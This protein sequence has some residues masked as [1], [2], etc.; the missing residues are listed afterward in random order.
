MD[1]SEEFAAK[2]ERYMKML[3]EVIVIKKLLQT[4]GNT[5]ASCRGDLDALMKVVSS[6]RTNVS[7]PIYSYKLSS[8]YISPSA[9]I[10]TKSIF[11]IAVVKIQNKD[12]LSLT[13]DEK[14]SVFN[15]RR[16]IDPTSTRSS[17]RS[18]LTTIEKHLNKKRKVQCKNDDFINCDF[19]V[20]SVAE[21]ERLWSVAKI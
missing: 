1:E 3:S 11:E 15:L 10:M 14:N 6:E 5:I 17:S 2:S 12:E 21:V 19:L 4:H 16:E 8:K 20:G 7:F 13:T 9:N 18:I